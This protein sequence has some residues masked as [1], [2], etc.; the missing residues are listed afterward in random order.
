MQRGHG[1]SFSVLPIAK[2]K[3]RSLGISGT[4]H[5]RGT[6]LWRPKIAEE[7][8]TAEGGKEYNEAMLRS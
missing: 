1:G 7:R 3:R 6:K 5:N 8:E 2:D 4:L